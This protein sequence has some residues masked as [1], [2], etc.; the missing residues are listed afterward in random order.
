GEIAATGQPSRLTWIASME[1]YSEIDAARL[2][3]RKG[4]PHPLPRRSLVDASG[5]GAMTECP[6][7]DNA[8]GLT[9]LP[10]KKGW[11]ARWRPGT[12]LV[13]RGYDPQ[14][15]RLW[16]GSELNEGD[17]AWIQDRCNALQSEMLVWGR[18]GAPSVS[19]FDGTLAALSRCYTADKDS[20][21]RSL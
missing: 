15:Y 9:W 17:I 19:Q 5:G 10:R 2:A 21:Y 8:P 4:A 20:A 18:G 7:I 14:V 11:E 13:K 3:D 1:H 12:D 6:K 16:A